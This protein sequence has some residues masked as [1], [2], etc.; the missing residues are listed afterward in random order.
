MNSGVEKY[1]LLT[2]GWLLV[3]SVSPLKMEAGYSCRMFDQT[4]TTSS[5][6]PRS[7]HHVEVTSSVVL[8][9]KTAQC[10]FCTA[11]ILEYSLFLILRLADRVVL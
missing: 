8:C 2:H 9:S 7:D 5:E 4:V 11:Q 10:L 1:S 6:N 3:A